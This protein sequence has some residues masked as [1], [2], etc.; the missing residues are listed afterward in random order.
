MNIDSP[1]YKRIALLRYIKKIMDEENR[2]MMVNIRGC[3][4]TKKPILSNLLNDGPL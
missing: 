2:G 3:Y 1:R 4:N